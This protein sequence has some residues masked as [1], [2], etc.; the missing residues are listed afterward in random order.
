MMPKWVWVICGL[1]AAEAVLIVLAFQVLA[2][3]ECRLTG[4]ETACRALRGAA[5]RAMCLGALLA[6]YLWAVPAAR[7]SLARI[8]AAR[9]GG[10]RGWALAHALAM[11]VVFAPL[12]LVAPDQLNAHFAG[13]FAALS[14]GGLAALVSGLFW[15]A[16]PSGWLGWLR[17]RAG[18]L[19]VIGLVALVL[20]DIAALIGPLWYWGILTETTFAAVAALI[21]T[22][23]DEVLVLPDMQV[24]G[25]NGFAVAVADSCSGVEGFALIAAF[26]GIYAWLFRDSLRMVPYWGI[27]LPVA[28]MLSWALN[29]LRI[30]ALVLIGAH[31]SPGLAQNGFHS[32]AG[33]LFF[34]VLAF[35]VL[36]AADRLPWLRRPGGGKAAPATPLAEDEV[37]TRIVPFVVFM[38]SGVV[39]QAFWGTPAL[40]FPL[41]A[42]AMALALWWGRR[43]IG[44]LLVRPDAVAV[45]AGAVVGIGWVWTAPAPGPAPAALLALSP[46]VFALWAGV[47]IAGT[48]LL[49]PMVEELFFRGYVQHHLDGDGWARRVLAIAASSA[50]FAALHGRYVAA[51]VAGV[52][53][54]LIYLRRGRLADAIAAHAV[55]NALIAV[56]AAWRG[57]WGLI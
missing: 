25:T 45:L 22:V 28:L 51:G 19:A 23:A 40:A 14:L 52:V 41:Q 46:V 50:L 11:A 55:A 30:A 53:F 48:A 20:P 38:V 2:P 8:A 54:A 39:V 24:I 3:V 57:D 34:M 33:W 17:A 29:V 6:V 10:G 27:V 1:F 56:V 21:S 7:H 37:A 47:R 44:P 15:L 26:M 9:A 18:M 16:A 4:I 12:L 36:L 5:V 13:V 49:V 43:A 42:A 31:V 35:G 32:F